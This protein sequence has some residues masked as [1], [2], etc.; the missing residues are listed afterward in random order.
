VN[1]ASNPERTGDL[2]EHRRVLDMGGLSCGHLRELQREPKDTRVGFRTWTQQDDTKKSTKVSS[3]NLR[4]RALSPRASFLTTT[5]FNA[6]WT[7][8]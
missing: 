2:D 4:I 5:T 7:F 6:C 3:L 1:D 8:S